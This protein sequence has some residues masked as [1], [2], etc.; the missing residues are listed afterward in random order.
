M[1]LNQLC[2]KIEDFTV[3]TQ[4]ALQSLFIEGEKPF[5]QHRADFCI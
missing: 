1:N 4:F 5:K 3:P 2:S